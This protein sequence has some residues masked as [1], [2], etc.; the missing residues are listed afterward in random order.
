M[1]R[2]EVATTIPAQEI[3]NIITET[4]LRE[5]GLMLAKWITSKAHIP[6]EADLITRSNV[7]T[8]S[9]ISLIVVTSA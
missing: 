2:R 9:H 8:I 5:T 4:V 3:K 6:I 1:E 7:S